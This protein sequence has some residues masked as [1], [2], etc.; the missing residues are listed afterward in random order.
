MNENYKSTRYVLPHGKRLICTVCPR[1]CHLGEGQSGF[2]R[3]RKNE[4]GR[5]VSLVY[6][7]PS[8]VAVDPIEKKPLFHFL[9]GSRVF[10]IGTAGCNL[11]CQF[12]QNWEL[13]R[14]NYPEI[15]SINLPPEQIP[16][17]ARSEGAAS[18][19]FTYNDPTVFVEYATDA[20][21]A[22]HEQGLA[23]VAVTAGYINSQ[24]RN[25]FYEHI[26]AVNIDL[27]G[28]NDSFYSKICQSHLKP[29]LETIE[30]AVKHGIW[31]ELTT[32][33]LTGYNDSESELTAE[34]KWIFSQLG[35]DVPLHLTAARPAFRMMDLV[36]TPISSLR[37]ARD[38]ALSQGLRYVYTGNVFDTEG[39]N[40]YCPFC[41]QLIIER[42]QF[43]VTRNLLAGT[44]KCPKCEATIPGI[45]NIIRKGS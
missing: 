9:P 17:L 37:R 44:S 10:S 36:P 15:K 18:V 8:A 29:V 12:C 26:D 40:T 35:P 33:L 23:T 1:E 39:E 4:N 11:G 22:C 20:A 45:F 34:T 7:R 43:M 32:L 13:S 27:K 14:A 38:I 19:A 28:F 6:G 24:A 30:W 2:C 16:G 21:I 25:D 5:L 41:D 31:V 42:T 3:A